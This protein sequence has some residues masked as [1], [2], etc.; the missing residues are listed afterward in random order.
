MKEFR[1]SAQSLDTICV[2]GGTPIRQHD[3]GFDVAFR[4]QGPYQ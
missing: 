3:C 4:T 2:Y 1:E